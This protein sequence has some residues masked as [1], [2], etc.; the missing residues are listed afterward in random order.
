[1]KDEIN[2]MPRQFVLRRER[3]LYILCVGRLLSRVF[4]LLLLLLV[5]Q[6]LILITLTK[7]R[8]DLT[9]ADSG[10]GADSYNVITE[11]NRANSFLREFNEVRAEYESW[12]PLV[13][14]LLGAVPEGITISS[15]EAEERSG[16]MIVQ[17]VASS[18]EKVVIF[19][20]NLERLSWVE[21]VDSPLQNFA[22]ETDSEFTF[23][24]SRS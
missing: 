19:Q 18:R 2:L 20:K 3:R 10:E 8:D 6:V 12:S 16:E 7:I 21:T 4:P 15:L 5:A 22:V 13:E 9:F 11:V 24:I 14:D 1:M 23:T 17:G